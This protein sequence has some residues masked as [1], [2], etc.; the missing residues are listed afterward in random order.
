MFQD[1]H[2]DK[3]FATK[4]KWMEGEKALGIYPICC[5]NNTANYNNKFS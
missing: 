1:Q 4:R 3:C 2:F 5:I